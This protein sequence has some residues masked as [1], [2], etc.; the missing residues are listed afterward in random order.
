MHAPT[1]RTTTDGRPGRRPRHHCTPDDGVTIRGAGRWHS[2][3]LSHHLIDRPNGGGNVK[4]Y[5]FA[6]IGE[7]TERND[8]SPD[9]FVNGSLGPNSIVSG[10][11]L[12][13]R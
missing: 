6:V 2:T 1:P 4:L 5:D 7:V 11:W 12:R 8:Q 9:N 3:L 13:R 10:L